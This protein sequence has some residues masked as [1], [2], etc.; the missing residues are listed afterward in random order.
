MSKIEYELKVLDGVRVLILHRSMVRKEYQIGNAHSEFYCGY[1]LDY[2]LFCIA[3]NEPKNNH[4]EVGRIF[5]LTLNFNNAWKDYL[6]YFQKGN[7]FYE[8]NPKASEGKDI[9]KN[10]QKWRIRQFQWRRVPVDQIDSDPNAIT[11]FYARPKENEDED[12][13]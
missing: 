12:D 7:D 11:V 4:G 10:I 1:C 13:D 3:D 8:K 2:G 6:W 5:N 9:F